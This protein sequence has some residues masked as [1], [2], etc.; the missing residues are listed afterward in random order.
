M[1]SVYGTIGVALATL[2]VAA[3]ADDAISKR[4]TPTVYLAGDST[5][6]RGGGGSLTDGM[7]VFFYPPSS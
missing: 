3:P 7:S 2:A 1:K 6:A 5:M 4:A